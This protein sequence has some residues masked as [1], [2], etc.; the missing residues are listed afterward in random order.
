MLEC[1]LTGKFLVK[2]LK[3]FIHTDISCTCEQYWTIAKL[4]RNYCMAGMI[5]AVM[6]HNMPCDIA[7]FV[8][9]NSGYEALGEL[10]VYRL[11]S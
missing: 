9:L 4:P 6:C 7:Q 2:N 11:L 10:I 3:W 5:W 8:H 1:I